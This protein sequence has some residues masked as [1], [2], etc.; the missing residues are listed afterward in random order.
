M[1]P[2]GRGAV[3]AGGPRQVLCAFPQPL[4]W[5]LR[6]LWPFAPLP[7]SLL[8]ATPAPRCAAPR[9]Q[10]LD[11]QQQQQREWPCPATL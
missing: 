9:T 11:P 1:S 7:S 5:W 3:S 6:P 2:G 4:L 10:P 8:S